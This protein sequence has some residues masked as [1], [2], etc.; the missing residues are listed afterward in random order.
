M[1]ASRQQTSSFFVKIFHEIELKRWTIKHAKGGKILKHCQFLR[2][3]QVLQVGCGRYLPRLTVR[4]CLTAEDKLLL[5]GGQFDYP[6]LTLSG[7]IQLPDKRRLWR[8]TQFI[9]HLFYRF[10]EGRLNRT[11][12]IVLPVLLLIL[13]EFWVSQLRHI[14][15]H[16]LWLIIK[17]LGCLFEYNLCTTEKSEGMEC[18]HLRSRNSVQPSK[19]FVF[20]TISN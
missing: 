10:W 7:R 20:I 4:Q 8:R 19:E 3:L 14:K 1:A 16:H 12:H 9:L 6:H 18:T 11:S 17:E 5:L 15:A 2:P 13:W